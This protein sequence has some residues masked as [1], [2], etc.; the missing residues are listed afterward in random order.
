MKT[1]TPNNQTRSEFG[2]Q[3]HPRKEFPTW[4]LDVGRWLFNSVHG[5]PHQAKACTTYTL[6]VRSP[7]FSVLPAPCP[8]TGEN[9]KPVDDHGDET[10]G[11]LGDIPPC[12]GVARSAKT[13]R[14]SRNPIPLTSATPDSWSAVGLDGVFFA[15]EARRAPTSFTTDAS[16]EWI[17]VDACPPIEESSSIKC[18]RSKCGDEECD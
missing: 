16:W 5:H 11:R 7:R 18:M 12:H 17:Q 8:L 9:T 14:R 2:M 10:D 15:A 1:S 4:T 3:A 6:P 13:G